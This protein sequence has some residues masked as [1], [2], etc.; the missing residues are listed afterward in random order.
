M[1]CNYVDTA[2]QLEANALW[3]I[4]GILMEMKSFWSGETDGER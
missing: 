3:E 4:G 2:L 1:Q